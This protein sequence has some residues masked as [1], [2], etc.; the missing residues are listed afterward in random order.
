M[1]PKQIYATP[2]CVVAVYE[3]ARKTL[4]VNQN[5]LDSELIQAL[6]QILILEF[7]CLVSYVEPKIL[8][9]R[10]RVANDS[11][12]AQMALQSHTSSLKAQ[13]FAR[14]ISQ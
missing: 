8:V 3:Q 4:Y 11:H 14:E 9:D 2:E 1:E 13:K 7:S 5:A 12:D 6:K 10:V